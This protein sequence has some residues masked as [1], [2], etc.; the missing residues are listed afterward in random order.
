MQ[1]E[2]GIIDQ[3]LK[4]TQILFFGIAATVAILT[5]RK[6]KDGLLNTVNTEYQKKVINRLDELAKELGSEFDSKS[7]N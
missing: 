7:P 2:P 4:V 1:P 3:I 5:Y 6:A